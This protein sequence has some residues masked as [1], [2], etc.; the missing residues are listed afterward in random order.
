[1]FI[2]QSTKMSDGEIVNTSFDVDTFAGTPLAV[3][4][5]ARP[6]VT[7]HKIHFVCDYCKVQNHTVRIFYP[8]DQYQSGLG[9]YVC[10]KIECVK[11][12]DIDIQKYYM[13]NNIIG[14]TE[15]TKKRFMLDKPINVQIN[16]NSVGGWAINK[17]YMKWIGDVY[18]SDYHG[19]YDGDYCVNVCGFI[20]SAF[21]ETHVL[22]T[23]VCMLNNIDLVEL[24]TA[25]QKD[26]FGH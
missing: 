23:D 12:C 8:I 22:L 1:M 7:P 25:M 14:M 13:D 6:N 15:E 18:D 2:S 4:S 19:D 26:T 5:S 10:H 9:I 3:M 20:N 21:F 16:G 24:F 17:N 11:Y